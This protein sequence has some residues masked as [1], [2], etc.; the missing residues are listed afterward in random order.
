M[1]HALA[2]CSKAFYENDDVNASDNEGTR[3][4]TKSQ[5]KKVLFSFDE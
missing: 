5:Y 3:S 1:S 2:R 4:K